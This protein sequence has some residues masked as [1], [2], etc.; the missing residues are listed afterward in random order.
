MEFTSEQL[1]LLNGVVDKA[2]ELSGCSFRPQVLPGREE[3]DIN[4]T[5]T[6]P[7]FNM[8]PFGKPTVYL[9]NGAFEDEDMLGVT[10]THEFIHCRQGWFMIYK[11][12]LGSLFGR[13]D[14]VEDEAYNSVNLWYD[15]QRKR[16][17]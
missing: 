11:S 14:F 4:G 8:W 6:W 10:L 17:H 15:A 1:D 3:S 16:M 2:I 5:T 12:K 7:F 13:P 9:T